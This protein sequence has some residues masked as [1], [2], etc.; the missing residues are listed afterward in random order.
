MT[1]IVI[2]TERELKLKTTGN[3]KSKL[4]DGEWKVQLPE[5]DW[6]NVKSIN[7]YELRSLTPDVTNNHCYIYDVETQGNKYFKAPFTLELK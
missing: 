3:F 5:I 4:I 7:G 1:T 6:K 2:N